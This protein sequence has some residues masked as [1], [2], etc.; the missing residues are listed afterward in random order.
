M[1][2]DTAAEDILPIACQIQILFTFMFV[3]LYRNNA[4][5][6]E[7]KTNKLIWYY[8]SPT[9]FIC[10]S[11]ILR[12]RES[13]YIVLCIHNQ[14]SFVNMRLIFPIL[15]NKYVNTAV[16]N[17]CIGHDRNSKR[18]LLELRSNK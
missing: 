12:T 3:L 6:K 16:V 5:K 13:I 18:H 15:D 9:L 17:Q 10:I 4:L 8:I 14:N 11:K 2:K 1:R 7:N